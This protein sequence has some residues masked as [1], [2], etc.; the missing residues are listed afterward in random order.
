M[1]KTPKRDLVAMQAD[2]NA[3]AL[4]YLQTTTLGLP[5]ELTDSQFDSIMTTITQS[6]VRAWAAGYA[7]RANEGK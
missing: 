6:L 2:A 7:A 4:E 1:A 3:Y 5:N